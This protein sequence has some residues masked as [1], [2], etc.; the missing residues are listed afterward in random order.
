MFLTEF[1]HSI[2]HQFRFSQ[3]APA[4]VG[5]QI[6]CCYAGTVYARR[7]ETPNPHLRVAISGVVTDEAGNPLKQAMVSVTW[8][9][10][11]KSSSL[12][13]QLKELDRGAFNVHTVPDGQTTLTISSPDFVSKQFFVTVPSHGQ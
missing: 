4:L 13:G 8:K 2:L 3:W 9:G 1:R 11:G 7:A 6:V 5:I 10:T 12:T